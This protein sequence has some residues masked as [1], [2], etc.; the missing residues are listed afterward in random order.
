[1]PLTGK[2]LL[3]VNDDGIHAKGLALLEET[4]RRFSNDVWVVAPQA[5]QSGM[6]RAISYAQRIYIEK[7]E[8]K[9]FAVQGSPADCTIFALTELMTD[10]PPYLVLS[11]VNHGANLAEDLGYSGTVGA[12]IEATFHQVPAIAFS[13]YFPHQ[14]RDRLDWRPAAGFLAEALTRL[15]G[16]KFPPHT[17]LNVNFPRG[18]DQPVKGFR[19]T[20]LGRRQTYLKMRSVGC[21]GHFGAYEIGYLRPEISANETSDLGAVLAGHISVTPI[22]SRWA[23]E[24][25]W[26]KQLAHALDKP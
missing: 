23:A 25:G 17:C 5:E 7:L 16:L 14:G 13:Q 24:E 3:L 19:L 10:A 21:E 8:E 20:E 15:G 12:A 2:R 9:R 4:A 11:G 6:S 22:A 1:M 18:G 26:V